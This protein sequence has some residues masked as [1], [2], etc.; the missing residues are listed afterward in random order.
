VV[1][2]PNA[3]FT[4]DAHSSSGSVSVEGGL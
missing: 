2:D 4:I 1:R 3:A